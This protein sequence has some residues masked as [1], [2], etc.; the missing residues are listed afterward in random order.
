[1]EPLITDYFRCLSLSERIY[2]RLPKNK[3]LSVPK[4]N[5]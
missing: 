2:E 4:A 1:M 3:T 5:S